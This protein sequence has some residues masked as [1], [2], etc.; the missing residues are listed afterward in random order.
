MSTPFQSV[1]IPDTELRTLSSANVRQEFNIFIALPHT[2]ATGTHTYPVLY[3]LDANG[4]FGMA[5]ETFRVL[6]FFN[7]MREI[8]IVGIGYPGVSTFPATMGLRTRDYTPTDNDWYETSYKT[9]PNAPEYAGEGEAA[10]FLQF[11]REELLPFITTNY[12]TLPEDTGIVGYSFGGLFAL[13]TLFHQPDTFK[14]YFVCSPSVW[15]GN[16]FLL[17]AEK[18]FA[19]K[20]SDLAAWLFMSV[21]AD[22]PQSMLADMY[23]IA[24]A[25]V[26]RK[27]KSLEMATHILEGAGHL[28]VFPP[29]ICR[30][31]K[32][33]YSQTG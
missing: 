21:G 32:A 6:N 15:W 22:E 4:L 17:G 11:I 13:Y 31:L 10:K 8:I 9:S 3:L 33:A 5:T 16:E 23:A 29:F 14:R 25:L 12:R 26:N 1:T 18:D 2:Y 27:Y 24:K 30:A 19:A 28:S 7:E 20:N